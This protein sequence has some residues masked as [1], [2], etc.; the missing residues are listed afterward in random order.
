MRKRQR[1]SSLLEFTL[2]GIPMIFVWISI[3]QIAI[4]MWRYHTLQF[5]V[6]QTGSYVAVHGS[7]CSLPGNSCA[8]QI[9]QAAQVLQSNAIGIPPD[10]ISVTFQVYQ[11]DHTTAYGSPVSCTLDNCL[12][13]ATVWPP[14][15]WN[16]PGYD[17]EISATYNFQSM[18]A[19]FVPGK[20]GSAVAG[21]NLPAYTRQMILF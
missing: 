14:A 8:I 18:V 6:K 20:G 10:L 9:Q 11:P 1:G 2:A 4:G 16:D 12:T 17:I 7:D 19:M 15:G 21:Q 5:A 3:V 13:N